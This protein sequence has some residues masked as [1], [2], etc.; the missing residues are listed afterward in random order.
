MDW[1]PQQQEA[2]DKIYRWIEYPTDTFRLFGYA[3]TGK[4]TLLKEIPEQVKG[5]V[6]FAAPTGKAASVL[7]D[8]GCSGASTIHKLIYIPKQKSK[9]RLQK[10]QE[11]YALEV[12]PL[13][14]LKLAN[15]IEEEQ[16]NLNRPSFALNHDSELRCASLL[17]IDEASM[18]GYK[19]GA[20]IAGFNIPVL[21]LGDPFQLPP[22]RDNAFYTRNNKPDFL[23]TEI[24]RQA[25]GSPVI[26]LSTK[27]RNGV[28]LKV[29]AY[30]DSFVI[31]KG[32]LSINEIAEYDQ[33]IVGM[34]NT[35]KILN[36]KIRNEVFGRKTHLP[37]K[38]D[39]LVCCKNNYENGLVNG[40]QWI[41]VS[42]IPL[43]DDPDYISLEIHNIDDSDKYTFGVLA[44]RHYFEDRENEI[45]HYEMS[46]ADHFDFA[47]A[48][49][50]HKAQGSQWKNVCVIDESFISGINQSRW[51][52][53]AITRASEKVTVIQQ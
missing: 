12:D 13:E 7:Q 32:R 19:V 40:S 36:R 23:L 45:P 52:Y 22:V 37:E 53:T 24:H 4:T 49:T 6:L 5:K 44:F 35:R 28:R 3:G 21:A 14:S 27:I 51:L 47:Y 33:I 48:I 11:Q 1:S 29:G 9:L 46:D 50:C 39:K 26:D 42:S 17:I 30:G 18:V 43:E 34:N 2:L 16:K 8:K 15:E 25:Q 10:L 41:V 20:D 38:G 31:P